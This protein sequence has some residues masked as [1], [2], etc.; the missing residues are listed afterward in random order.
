MK[1]KLTV[2]NKINY[3]KCMILHTKKGV[4]GYGRELWLGSFNLSYCQLDITEHG[5]GTSILC[6]T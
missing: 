3:E 4:N 6:F 5:F 2:E 1:I